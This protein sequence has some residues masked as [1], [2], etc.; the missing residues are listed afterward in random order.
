MLRKVLHVQWAASKMSLKDILQVT[1]KTLIKLHIGVSFH[2]DKGYAQWRQN[3]LKNVLCDSAVLFP[4][5]LKAKLLRQVIYKSFAYVS[6]FSVP[7]PEVPSQPLD[8][9]RAQSHRLHTFV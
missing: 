5:I 2:D 3:L 4:T 9:P 8:I 1:I 7:I 6:D